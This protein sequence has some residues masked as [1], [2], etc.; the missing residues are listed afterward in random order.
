MRRTVK[1]AKVAIWPKLWQNLRASR[2]SELLRMHDIKDVCNWLGNTPATVFKH[3][4]RT[5]NDALRKATRPV[6]GD[7]FGD[8]HTPEPVELSG[9]EAKST[10]SREHAEQPKNQQKKPILRK[11]AVKRSIARG[12]SVLPEGIQHQRKTR[13]KRRITARW[14]AGWCKLV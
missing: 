1:R 14:C 10:E 12:R 5:N 9:T 8:Q 4:L 2:E 7:H 13:G 6:A 3:Y 11:T